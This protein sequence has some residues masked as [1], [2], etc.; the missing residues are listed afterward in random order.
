MK[1]I[2]LCL[3]LLLGLS[4]RGQANITL[5][6]L[7]A[8][9]ATRRSAS[10]ALIDYWQARPSPG[11]LIS[12]FGFNNGAQQ[13]IQLFDTTN[14][15]PLVNISSWNSTL[16]NFT[17]NVHGLSIGQPVQL[18][19]NTAGVTAGIY[20][21]GF[22]T[23]SSGVVVVEPNSFYLYDTVAHAVA[24]TTVG[25]QDVTTATGSVAVFNLVPFHTF[26]VAATD[27]YSCI[28]PSTGINF[29]KSLLIAVSTT[30]GTYTAGAKDVTMLATVLSR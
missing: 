5:S 27:N 16:D 26:A 18:S 11:V 8:Q 30:A 15:A 14:A 12:L 29:G 22:T 25:R 1:T 4:A 19:T 7:T 13:Y 28:V 21:V 3:S 23:N 9:S 24:A 6:S 10:T 17:N 20:Y 2:L